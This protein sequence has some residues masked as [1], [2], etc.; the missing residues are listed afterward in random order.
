MTMGVPCVGEATNLV[1]G[2]GHDSANR[3]YCDER[4]PICSNCAHHKIDCT[5]VT[6]V[7]AEPS[8][9]SEIAAE[10]RRARRSRAHQNSTFK[11]K[12]TF[13]SLNEGNEIRL[14]MDS[15]GVKYDASTVSRTTISLADL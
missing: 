11:W 4:R 1:S 15:T 6:E 14:S 10:Q 2:P 12:H 8:S 9:L 5:F 7:V 3:L 13:V